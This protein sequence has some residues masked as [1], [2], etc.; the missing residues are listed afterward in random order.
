MWPTPEFPADLVAFSEEIFN[1]K[2][3]FWYGE[4]AEEADAKRA[5]CVL[6]VVVLMADFSRVFF[7]PA[8]NGFI[9]NGFLRSNVTNEKGR[10]TFLS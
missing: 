8:G 2:H 1:G 9:S 4:G 10:V 5:E 7:Y 6:K 3:H